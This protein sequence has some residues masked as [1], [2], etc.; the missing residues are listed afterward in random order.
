MEDLPHNQVLYKD[1]N[2]ALANYDLVS[3]KWALSELI[4][5]QGTQK[6]FAK[7][8]GI[9]YGSLRR[10]LSVNGNPT[11]DI[12]FEILNGLNRGVVLTKPNGSYVT[13][14]YLEELSDGRST[15]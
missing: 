1:L 15:P 12:F 2:E 14:D 9:N 3:I 6:E 13:Q 4:K 11:A 7:K 8:T 10:A 5:K